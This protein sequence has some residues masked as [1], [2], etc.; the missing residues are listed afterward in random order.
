MKLL[1]GLVHNHDAKRY[2]QIRPA[3]DKLKE[4]LS[5]DWDIEIFEI[6]EE[7]EIVPHSTPMTMFRMVWYWKINREWMR[8][9]LLAPRNI[10]LDIAV[11][12]RRLVLTYIHRIAENKRSVVQT[13]VADKH[14]R[15]WNELLERKGDFLICFEDDAVF[16]SNSISD[17]KRLL[18]EIKKYSNK[19]VYLDFAGGCTPEYLRLENLEL[20][21]D[22]FRKYYKK[23]ATNTVCSYMINSKSAKTFLLTILV[24][25]RLR[26]L[27]GDWL[28]NKLFIMT[29]LKNNY[30]CYHA[31]PH[32]FRHGSTTGIYESSI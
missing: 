23:P 19:H 9:R 5:S 26:L 29:A 7:P 3:L 13:F 31:D 30:Y 18:K 4:E 21:S 32:I 14:I 20:K 1:L 16:T 10:F 22:N 12:I 17:L 2:S 24:Y 25:P 28:L 11:L 27:A 15:A 8:Y 6:A